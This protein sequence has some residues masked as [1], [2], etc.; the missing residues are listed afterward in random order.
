VTTDAIVVRQGADVITV[1]PVGSMVDSPTAATNAAIAAAVATETAARAAADTAEAA[2]RAAADALKIPLTQRAVANGVATL[3]AGSKIPDAQIPD[4]IA[5]DAEMASAIAAAV[6]ALVNASPAA[7]DTLAELATA[8]GNDAAFAATVTTALAAR[9]LAADLTTETAARVAADALK[10]AKAGDTMTGALALP[11]VAV[12][13]ENGL[14]T[15]RFVGRKLTSGAPTTGTWVVDAEVVDSDGVTW[16]CLVAGTPGTWVQASGTSLAVTGAQS[17]DWGIPGVLAASGAMFVGK[18]ETYGN[19]APF[20]QLIGGANVYNG[21]QDDAFYFA[22]YNRGNGGSKFV[23]AE[24]AFGHHLEAHVYDNGDTRVGNHHCFEWNF[25][26]NNTITAGGGH[27]LFGFRCERDDAAVFTRWAFSLGNDSLSHFTVQTYAG[28]KV[29]EVLSTGAA[30]ILTSLAVP[31]ASMTGRLGLGGAGSI[32]G[33]YPGFADAMVWDGA[34]GTF[35]LTQPSTGV[36]PLTVKRVTGASASLAKI[37]TEADVSL[38]EVLANGGVKL[39]NGT[40]LSGQGTGGNT[41]QVSVGSGGT[42]TLQIGDN[43]LPGVDLNVGSGAM[44]LFAAGDSIVLRSMTSLADAKNLVLATG[45]GSKIGTA[46]S[47]KLGFWNATPVVQQS[48]SGS[49]GGNAALASL[50]SAGATAGL[51]ADATSA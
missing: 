29:L 7:L 41:F 19:A 44:R 12:T 38:W 49:R 18:Y 27:R 25:D 1:V 45:T 31:A 17:F 5:R 26:A 40:T 24:P 50:L 39:N 42:N 47:Q 6:A 3:D 33:D 43:G 8:L 51:W 15:R 20:A 37:T 11:A 46:T 32:H 10:V 22:S 21:Q 16:R 48:V 35:K 4:S 30:S 23:D 28:A 36:V 2:A 34:T 9:A 14:S 13:G